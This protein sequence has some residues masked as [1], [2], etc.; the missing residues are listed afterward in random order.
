MT[1]QEDYSTLDTV[2]AL[3]CEVNRLDKLKYGMVADSDS[4]VS[5]LD[6]IVSASQ[7]MRIEAMQI[8]HAERMSVILGQVYAGC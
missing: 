6:Y 4:T 1:G 7:I 3:M 5:T 8:R 2:W